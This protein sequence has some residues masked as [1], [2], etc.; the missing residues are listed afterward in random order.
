MA[1]GAFRLACTS[2]P[3]AIVPVRGPAVADHL[4][5]HMRF[6]VAMVAAVFTAGSAT[7][8]VAQHQHG[9]DMSASLIGGLGSSAFRL[10]TSAMS[11]SLTG[12]CFSSESAPRPLYGL[13]FVKELAR[14]ATLSFVG[15]L[16]RSQSPFLRPDLASLTSM[17]A[18]S[19][20]GW[21]SPQPCGMLRP[22]QAIP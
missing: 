16:V 6:L 18:K 19:V 11:M 1:R 7:L 10:S 2:S 5:G 22:C 3:A 17:R 15:F 20:Q 4:G 9:H 8:A 14:A 13:F 21:L 12:S